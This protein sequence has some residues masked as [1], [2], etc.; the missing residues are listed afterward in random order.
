MSFKRHKGVSTQCLNLPDKVQ[1]IR[2]STGN[3]TGVSAVQGL[4]IVEKVGR[5]TTGV[6]YRDNQR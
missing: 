4:G 3:E 6:C 2:S 5:V 1:E